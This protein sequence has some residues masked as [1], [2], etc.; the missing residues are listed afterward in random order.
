MCVS[1][2]FSLSLSPSRSSAK[3][4]FLQ[5]F[6][7]LEGRKIAVLSFLALFCILKVNVALTGEWNFFLFFFSSS[8]AS[9]RYMGYRRKFVPKLHESIY[10]RN[11]I[12]PRRRWNERWWVVE[13]LCGLANRSINGKVFQKTGIPTRGVPL[14]AIEGGRRKGRWRRIGKGFFLK[15]SFSGT[16]LII[17]SLSLSLSRGGR[18]GGKLLS[19][20]DRP[21]PPT[22]RPLFSTWYSTS[23]SRPRGTMRVA[24]SVKRDWLFEIRESGPNNAR[25]RTKRRDTDAVGMAWAHY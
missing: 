17:L 4:F 13:G 6:C 11:R 25:E 2:S 10:M 15:L 14:E 22:P 9:F 3:V 18:F 12:Y 24:I 20:D 5:V 21:L 19:D 23:S 16:C 8:A 1:L 7:S